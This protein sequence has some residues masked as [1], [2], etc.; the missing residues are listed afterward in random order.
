VSSVIF[1]W[2]KN[3]GFEG[4][5]EMRKIDE[6]YLKNTSAQVHTSGR[7]LIEGSVQQLM[8][9]FG[10]YGQYLGFRLRSIS[11]LLFFPIVAILLSLRHKGYGKAARFFQD[12]L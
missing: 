9:I 3:G 11:F 7:S 2:L 4:L 6:W 5:E 8:A 10:N 12:L 1:L